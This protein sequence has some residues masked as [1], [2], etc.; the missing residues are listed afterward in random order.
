MD[1]LSMDELSTLLGRFSLSTPPRP[2]AA[3]APVP[4]TPPAPVSPTKQLPIFWA[5]NQLPVLPDAVHAA[6]AGELASPRGGIHQFW[7]GPATDL[8]AWSTTSRSARRAPSTA[9]IFKTVKWIGAGAAATSGGGA[10]WGPP[11]SGSLV[12]LERAMARNPQMRPERLAIVGLKSQ[13]LQHFKT[14]HDLQRAER[15]GRHLVALVNQLGMSRSP[16]LTHVQLDSVEL[17]R[18]ILEELW[19]RLAQH[20]SLVSLVL[21]GVKTFEQSGVGEFHEIGVKLPGLKS[22]QVI[23]GE[24]QHFRLKTLPWLTDKLVSLAWWTHKPIEAIDIEAVKYLAPTLERL[25]LKA[26]NGGESV[27]ELLRSISNGDPIKMEELVLGLDGDRGLDLAGAL[28][29]MP[30][31]QVLVLLHAGDFTPAELGEIVAAAPGLTTLVLVAGNGSAAVPW[32]STKRYAEQLAPLDQLELFGW[33]FLAP[34]PSSRAAH[35]KSA[36]AVHA[37][38][39]K[40]TLR[41]LGE[42]F[43]VVNVAGKKMVKLVRAFCL[44]DADSHLSWTGMA[45][46]WPRTFASKISPAY[47]DRA[48]L[49]LHDVVFARWEAL[50]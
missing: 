6:I 1:K 2:A 11:T 20:T 25:A 30:R 33:D 36:E 50:A 5:A 4:A 37:M 43:K 21:R 13:V 26:S 16:S 39:Q 47:D 23:D 34:G 7:A 48:R 42:P 17:Y 15:D 8:V 49:S 19:S 24:A 27:R 3:A 12:D 29:K 40:A 35:A 44:E 18:S 41:A 46:S 32:H 28:E 10:A 14:D 31:L 9:A 45:A 22:L 38:S